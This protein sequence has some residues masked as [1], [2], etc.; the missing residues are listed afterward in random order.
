MLKKIT[1]FFSRST[2]APAAKAAL[3]HFDGAAINRFT[4]SWKITSNSIDQELRGNLDLLRRRSRELAK[5]DNYVK[6]FLELVEVNV[7]GPRGFTLQVRVEDAPGKPDR[8]AND[9]IERDFARWGR[10]DFCDVSGKMSFVDFQRA[11]I[12]A[13]ERDGE[14]LI[15]R[16]RG[17]NARNKYNFALQLLDIERLDTRYNFTPTVAGQ[18]SIVMG[19]ELD[20]YQRP[21]GYWLHTAHPG[22]PAGQRQREFIP[23]ADAL[24][25]FEAMTPEQTRGIPRTHSAMSGL[26]Q[27]KGYQEAAVIAARAGAAKMGFFTSKEGDMPPGY[28]DDGDAVEG[29]YTMSAEAGEFGILPTGVDFTAYDPTYPHDQYP[30]FTKATLRGISSGLGV[31]YHSLGNDLEGVNF[32]SIRSGTLEERDRWMAKQDWFA[33]AC[34]LPIYED[35]LRMALLSQAIKLPNGSP[36]P[37]AKYDKFAP[38]VW[39]GRRWAWVDPLKDINASVEAMKNGL[40]SPQAI[41]ANLGVQLEDVID[42][43]AHADT[44]AAAAGLPKYS[45]PAIKP[46]EANNEKDEP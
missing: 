15:L 45:A 7:V 20:P 10:A 5:N 38:H 36:L 6:K 8:L 32:S 2:P 9:A 4:E 21:V 25:V 11:V 46:S 37:L 30:E 39:Q 1:D 13:V 26:H 42:S 27:L 23:A 17:K 44:L 33:N 40:A 24:H 18:N 12:K 19:V 16:V 3:R 31:A 29:E 34:L 14:A 22:G 35:W 43:L 28:F 41:C